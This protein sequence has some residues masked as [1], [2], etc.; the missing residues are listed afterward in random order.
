MEND[1]L[2]AFKEVQKENWSLFAPLEAVTT[3]CAAS[4]VRF[5]RIKPGDKV[6]D[7]ACGTGV[8]AITAAKIGAKASGID[9][10][11]ALVNRAQE[12]TAIANVTV[13]VQEGD[14]ESLPFP[15]HSFD[16][17]LSQ[18]GHMFAPRPQVAIQEMLRVLKPGGIIAFSTWPPHLCVGKMFGLV[19]KFSPPPEGVSPPPLWGEPHFVRQQLA[20]A[21]EDL[22]FAQDFML[23][24]ALSLGHYQQS[25]ET[26][27]IYEFIQNLKKEPARLEQFRKELQTLVSP[28]YVDNHL[29]QHYL[30]SR[31]RKK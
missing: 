28:Y 6:L 29:H 14:V 31:A 23:F 22:A 8:V 21:V 24:P 25:I 9:L 19:S 10:C 3:I 17:V 7:V 20:D 27:P 18:F 13:D 12:N 2:I 4:L 15:D 26:G 5:S 11:P 1:A 30:M 16:A